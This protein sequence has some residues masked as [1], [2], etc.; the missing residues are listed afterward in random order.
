MPLIRPF[1]AVRYKSPALSRLLCP[2]YDIIPPALAARLRREPKNAVHLELPSGDG[3]HLTGDPKGYARARADWEGWLAK[4]VL[5]RDPRPFLYICE[6]AWG[7]NRR[8]GLFADLSL[9]R[10]ASRVV[11]HERTFSKPK[12]DRLE[13]LKA[14]GANTSPIFGIVDDPGRRV[15]SALRR[16][17]R[18]KPLS[19][20][21]DPA[22]GRVR[23]WAV[24]DPKLASLLADKAMLIADGHHRFSVSAD[25][26]AAIGRDIG[27]LAYIASEADPGLLLLPTHRVVTPGAPLFER[28]KDECALTPSASVKA[29]EAALTRARGVRL[30][31][32]YGKGRWL[33]RPKR[34]SA[35]LPVEW[36]AGALE[37]DQDR[38]VY[39]HD[40]AEAETLA[41]KS[42]G[43]A[44]LL[45][46]PSVREVREAVAARGLLP[47]KS[48]YFFPKV[49][50]G[51]VFRELD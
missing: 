36:L 15:L 41:R 49:P 11:P 27:C 7:K 23:L 35:L 9:D 46:A 29:L 19:E 42:G 4:G 10:A 20:G 34:R 16:A 28:L 3:S 5:R 32:A 12:A 50:T 51:L 31:L 26:A 48:T 8:L 1:A 25:H 37:P 44:V 14:L 40:G 22:G 13:L 21:R 2:P 17:T 39:T 24:E 43:L 33:A 38:V 45:P 47:Q 6:Q 30:G 18:S